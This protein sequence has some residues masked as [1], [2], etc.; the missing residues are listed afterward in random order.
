V[1]K[2][3]TAAPGTCSASRC[4]G[5]RSSSRIPQATTA[6]TA[7]RPPQCI[8]PYSPCLLMT[9]NGAAVTNFA[10]H[11]CMVLK[12]AC[13]SHLHM[14]DAFVCPSNDA[15]GRP[16][17]CI[18]PYR[19]CL[20]M[21]TNG[22]VVTNVAVHGCMVL[23]PACTAHLHMIDAF[24]SPNNDAAGRPPQC[25][26]PYRA[27]LLMTTNRAVVTN[28]A[29]H[30]C[31]VLKPACTAHVHMIDA[32]VSPNNDADGRPPKCI[33]T[34]RACLLMITNGAVVTNVAVHGCMVLKPACTAHLHMFFALVSSNNDAC[35]VAYLQS[36][37]VGHVPV[38]AHTRAHD[39]RQIQLCGNRVFGLWPCATTGS[40][41]LTGS[42]DREQYR[43][44]S[45]TSLD[46]KRSS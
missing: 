30:G 5:C 3:L 44:T 11:G 33:H 10:V 23:K 37:S 6:D 17:Q 26:L 29:A 19:A 40:I 41:S 39:N 35:V 32:F 25:I 21:T 46:R 9:T 36:Q 12:P 22:A 28:V 43:S 1:R 31:M 4:P 18:H 42:C 20:L 8:H 16:P 14:I 45:L 38:S 24:V 2:C 34:Y 27:C 15:A 13:T 7:G